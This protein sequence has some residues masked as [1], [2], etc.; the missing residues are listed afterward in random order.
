[1]KDDY[2]DEE[3]EEEKEAFKNKTRIDER[4]FSIINKCIFTGI[5]QKRIVLSFCTSSHPRSWRNEGWGEVWLINSFKSSV[6]GCVRP[7][8]L[9][10]FGQIYDSAHFLLWVRF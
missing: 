7:R 5:R 8:I 3:E 4:C 1:M 2:Q 9:L 10:L 6:D